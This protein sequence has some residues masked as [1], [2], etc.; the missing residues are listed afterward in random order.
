[1]TRESLFRFLALSRRLIT[2]S[3]NSRPAIS[4]SILVSRIANQSTATSLRSIRL[5]IRRLRSPSVIADN[6]L[7]HGAAAL[8]VASGVTSAVD[9]PSFQS[10][11]ATSSRVTSSGLKALEDAHFNTFRI[12]SVFSRCASLV[13]MG[14]P[15]DIDATRLETALAKSS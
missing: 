3:D 4:S 6:C 8:A 15:E 13:D 14:V 1:M 5:L 9:C 2:Q 12:Y 11:P 7:K 10:R